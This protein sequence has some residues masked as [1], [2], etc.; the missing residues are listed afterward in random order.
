MRFI[1][2]VLWL[3]M[4]GMILLTLDHQERRIQDLEKR[5]TN[6]ESRVS[7]L[8]LGDFICH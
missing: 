4:I 8:E 5:T 1:E 3:A 6:L 7:R 2:C